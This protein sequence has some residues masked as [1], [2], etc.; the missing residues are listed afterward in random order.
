MNVRCSHQSLRLLF[1]TNRAH[2]SPPKNVS[3]G[4][5]RCAAL[6]GPRCKTSL[7][8]LLPGGALSSLI[9]DHP[10]FYRSILFG[11]F[12]RKFLAN[13]KLLLRNLRKTSL[14]NLLPGGAFSSLI[15]YHPSFCRWLFSV[16]FRADPLPICKFLQYAILNDTFSFSDTKSFM[17]LLHSRV[18]S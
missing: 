9:P 4:T 11:A 16:L 18:Q 6:R 8:N 1:P 7:E 12:L 5:P 17:F 3:A 15:P 2:L 13:I 14:E 10:S